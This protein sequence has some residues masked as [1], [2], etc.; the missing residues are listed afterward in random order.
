MTPASLTP[1]SFRTYAP[2]AR[3]FAIEHLALLRR[4]PLSVCPSFLRQIK[5]LDTSFPAE[6]ATLLWQCQAIEA[7]PSAQFDSLLAPLVSIAL[8]PALQSADWVQ[9]PALFISN[10]T[11]HLWSSRQIDAFRTGTRNLFAVV[12]EHPNTAH[13]LVIVVLGQGMQSTPPHSLRQLSQRGVRLT[14]LQTN[15]ATQDIRGLLNRATQSAPYSTWYV[16]G[17]TP[18][19]G[20][21]SHPIV[22]V[23]Y[24]GL[25]PLRQRV[26]DRMENTL[27]SGNS[28]PEQLRDRLATT[29]PADVSSHDITSDPV[30]QR[31]YTEL[32]TESSGPQVF[33]T[34]FVQW[35]GRELARRA[36]PETLLL[37]YAPRQKHRD[38]NQMLASD[39]PVGVDVEGSFRDAEMGRTTTGS[40]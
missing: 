18:W 12:P 6:R 3:Q 9:S 35:T 30:L 40:R 11:A 22:S 7:L 5:D 36:Q 29:S 2:L 10:L 38:M 19:D 23:S 17:G 25:A 31:F 26:L 39:T 13:R 8:T 15:T 24:P 21:G 28:G 20:L 33:S 4:L 37:R 1:V 16:D 14:A 32:F 34:S 27:S